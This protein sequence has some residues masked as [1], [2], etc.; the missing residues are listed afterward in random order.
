MRVLLP[1]EREEN[2]LE[3][4]TIEAPSVAALARALGDLAHE[5]RAIVT[6]TERGNPWAV[7]D[8]S[9][10]TDSA[11]AIFPCYPDPDFGGFRGDTAKRGQ[12]GVI[13]YSGRDNS[14]ALTTVIERARRMCRS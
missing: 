6:A 5:T 2:I 10:M 14:H 3:R 8:I 1:I 13:V 9:P 7:V 4:L 12:S 11:R